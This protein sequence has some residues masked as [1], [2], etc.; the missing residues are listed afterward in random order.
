MP[1]NSTKKL[2]QKCGSIVYSCEKCNHTVQL[3]VTA[4]VDETNVVKEPTQPHEPHEPHEPHIDHLC[5]LPPN[6][7]PS[8]LP[9]LLTVNSSTSCTPESKEN[10]ACLLSLGD[11]MGHSS[12][13]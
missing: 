10:V 1:R 3:H 9:F 8:W 2:N 12:L 6:T 11:S 5:K 13:F 4:K 7:L